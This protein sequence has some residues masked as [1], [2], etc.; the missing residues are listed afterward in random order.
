MMDTKEHNKQWHLVRNNNGEWISGDYAEFLTPLEVGILQVKASQQGIQLD[1]QHGADGQ[2][3]CYKHQLDA[4][5]IEPINKTVMKR[6]LRIKKKSLSSYLGRGL[7]SEKWATAFDKEG[8]LGGLIEM[9]KNDDELVL[10]IREDYF[11]VYYKGGNMLKVSSENSF[12]FDYNYFKCEISLDT[13]EQRKKRIDKRRSILD[14]LK[15]TRDYKTFIDEM[16][17]LMD[18]YWIWLYNEKHRSLH[19]KDTQHALCISNTESTDYTIIDLE[20]QVSIRKDCTY[21]Y[22]PSSLPR[23]PGIYVCEKSPRF[24]IIAVRNS[25]RRLCVIELKNGLDALV[26]KSGIGDHADSFE[27]SIGKN[28]LAELTF[29]K[30][31]E[32]VVSDKKR[33]KLLSD[34]FYIDEKLPIEFIYAYAFKS[35]DE[36]GK[37]AERDSFLREQEKACCMNYKVIYLNK[38]DFTLSDSNC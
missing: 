33:L 8:K 22:E 32:K 17:K 36:N 14:S 15:N 30:E 12:Q 20:F 35:E 6:E 1:I 28:P 21:H 4:I 5:K 37:K 18:K 29:T 27:G 24:D 38:G 31:M 19:E 34:D 9:V 13:Q 26:G 11:N 3:W 7:H 23:H 2:L 10:Q 25:D 16:K